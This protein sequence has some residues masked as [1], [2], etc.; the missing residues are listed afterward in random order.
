[1]GLF[2]N[3]FGGKSNFK[4]AIKQMEKAYAGVREYSDVEYG[5]IIDEFIKERTANAD[6]YSQ[7]YRTAVDQYTGLMA[8][9][10]EAFKQSA[11]QAYQTLATGRTASMRL[12]QQQADLATGRAQVSGMLT[13]L[14]NTTFGQNYVNAVAAQGALQVAA[15]EEQYAQTLASARMGQASALAQMEQGAAQ[16]LFS[17]GLGSAQYQSGQYQQ[18]TTA[19]QAARSARLASNLGF[20]TRPIEARFAADTQL[21][22]MD[23][24]SGSAL[25]GALLGAGIGA[26]AEQVGGGIG[27]ALGGFGNVFGGG[28]R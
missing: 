10:R 15:I 7:A 12:M 16:T 25:G 8:Q 3:L 20:R 21:A 6:V 17:A 22:M 14:A 19:A 18:Y 5:K 26:L 11:E 28:N 2:S 1:M 23:M 4:G 27:S 13:G 24:Q 9:S